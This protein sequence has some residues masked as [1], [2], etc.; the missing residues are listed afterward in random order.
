[1]LN[2][3]GIHLKANAF[4]RKNNVL[5]AVPSGE[6]IKAVSYGWQPFTRANLVNEVGLP[7]STFAIDL[8]K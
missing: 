1:M 8:K 6:K 4:I 2:E 7:A 3:K 5:I